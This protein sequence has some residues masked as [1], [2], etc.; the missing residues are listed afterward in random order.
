LLWMTESLSTKKFGD[1]IATT[2][3]AETARNGC[4]AAVPKNAFEKM[5]GDQTERG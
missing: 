4:F 2:L 3:N 1:D 5:E